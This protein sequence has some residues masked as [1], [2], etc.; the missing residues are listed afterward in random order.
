MGQKIIGGT[1]AEWDD[2]TPSIFRLVEQIGLPETRRV[3]TL[4]VDLSELRHGFTDQFIYNLRDLLI[5]WRHRVSLNTLENYCDRLRTLFKKIITLNLFDKK[6]DTIDESFLLTLRSVKG[7]LPEISLRYFKIAFTVL[8]YSPLWAPG[9]HVSDFPRIEGVKDEHGKIINRILF[10]SLSRAACVNILK[11]CELAYDSG[12]MDISHFAF[13]NLS[14]AVFCRPES[15]RQI[16]LT[17]LVFDKKSSAYFLYITPAKTRVCNPEKLCYRINEP[18]GILLQKQRQ[19][20]I[21]RFSHLV[22]PK[23]VGKLALF[24]ARKLCNNNSAWL[25]K[26]ANEYQGMYEDAGQF[27]QAYPSRIQKLFLSENLNIR[28]QV[29]RHT[30]GTQLAQA[31]ASAR[32]IQGVLKHA[33]DN[34]CQIYVD[35]A[36]NGLIDELSDAMKPAFDM[37]LPTL[38]RFRSK[39]TSVNTERAI[40]SDDLETGKIELTG[41][42]GKLI[43]CEYAPITCYGCAR[44]IPCCDADHSINLNAVQREID[45]FR[46]RGRPFQHM[47]EKALEVK[48][49]ILLVMNAVDRYRQS[50]VVPSAE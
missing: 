18:V 42:C 32:T 41:E 4:R 22:D 47:V 5:D 35:I 3:V 12:E 36:F 40:R 7:C 23:D 10:T 24:P 50:Q 30:V 26:Y 25:H 11:R 39:H 27:M 20:V 15:Y 46:K 38:A 45:D 44:F 43:K 17:D 2:R 16:R 9:L 31:G 14:F 29:L 8:P 28:A 21:A 6:I 48:Y 49:Q 1:F 34:I 37:H 19:N 13:V 33:T